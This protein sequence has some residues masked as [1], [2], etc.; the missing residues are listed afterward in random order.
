MD[1]DVHDQ[2]G[3]RYEEGMPYNSRIIPTPASPVCSQASG[4]DLSMLSSSPGAV[5]CNQPEPSP[6]CQDD[7][8]AQLSST[9]Y[10][11]GSFQ[12]SQSGL[13]GRSYVWLGQAQAHR[14]EMLSPAQAC[15]AESLSGSGELPCVDNEEWGLESSQ[16]VAPACAIGEAAERVHPMPPIREGNCVLASETCFSDYLAA[17][18]G[19]PPSTWATLAFDW[20]FPPMSSYEELCDNVETYALGFLHT[21]NWL[22]KICVYAVKSKAFERCSLSLIL[23]NCVVLALDSK[24]PDNQHTVM[25][26][27]FRR[28]EWFFMIAFTVEM[29]AKILGLGLFRASGAY[30][31]DGWN[32]VDCIVVIVGWLSLLPSIE[33]IS[34]MRSVRV[35]R[36]LRTITGVEG[37]RMIVGTLLQSLPM[38]LD[39]LIL[40]AFLFLIFGII[41]VQSFS[42]VLRQHCGHPKGGT[43]AG[44]LLFNVSSVSLISAE[45]CGDGLIRLPL[46]GAWFDTNGTASINFIATV[47]CPLTWYLS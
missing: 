13:S 34:A 21:D 26:V 43:I 32:V 4:S 19:D 40:C 45:S 41:G 39:V 20:M 9:S 47:L 7:G 28:L 38:L 29:I 23:I 22:R 18:L 31:R 10:Q 25:G 46:E 37:M 5:A 8:T 42:G 2:S 33:N 12:G 30:L 3:N 14:N 1:M 27:V 15:S 6:D 16:R 11:G 44:S 24:D 35:L 36:P 17:D